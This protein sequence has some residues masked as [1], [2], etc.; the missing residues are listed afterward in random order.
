LLRSIKAGLSGL[1][2]CVTLAI[3]AA[4]PLLLEVQTAE[5]EFDQRTG[6]PIVTFRLTADS[7][8]RFAA[9]TQNNVGRAAEFRVDGRTLMKPV[10]R[11]PILGGTG[12]ISASLTVEQAKALAARLSSGNARIEVE[13]VPN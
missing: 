5:A 8:R 4:Q 13:A 3:A 10:I 12:Q 6:Q 9:F 1:F 11:E 2:L 7:A